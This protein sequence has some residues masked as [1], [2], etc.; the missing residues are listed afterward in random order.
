MTKHGFLILN[1]NIEVF[2]FCYEQGVD[3]AVG[4]CLLVVMANVRLF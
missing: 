3:D 4:W 1:L 2:N